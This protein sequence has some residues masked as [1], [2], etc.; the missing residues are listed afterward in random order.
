[1]KNKTK[2]LVALVAVMMIGFSNNSFAQRV[3]A[4]IHFSLGGAPGYYSPAPAYQYTNVAYYGHDRYERR[5]RWDRDR[6]MYRWND[7]RMM[8]RDGY[9]YRDRGCEAPRYNNDNYNNYNGYN[10]N[11]YNGY[12]NNNYNGYNNRY[13]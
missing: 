5:R 8:N 4:N 2:I 12:N 11:G 1:M 7:G 9:A 13:R 6:D 10:N 3:S